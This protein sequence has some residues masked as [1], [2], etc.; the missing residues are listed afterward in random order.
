MALLC[1][2]IFSLLFTRLFMYKD[3]ILA[4]N[5]VDFGWSLYCAPYLNNNKC[6]AWLVVKAN[7]RRI[8]S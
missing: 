8:M 6:V 5:T 7:D 3:R 1:A 2:R 4:T